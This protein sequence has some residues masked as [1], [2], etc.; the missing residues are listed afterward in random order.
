MI[1]HLGSAAE[2]GASC[3]LFDEFQTTQIGLGPRS[4]DQEIA[5]YVRRQ[6]GVCPMIVH[7]DPAAIRVTVDPLAALPFGEA[8]VVALQGT[9][10][11]SGG[12]VPE[13]ARRRTTVIRW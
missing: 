12:D 5:Q 4:A 1:V 11:A 7:D 8:E 9:D 2:A 3:D 10:D 6:R 13:Q